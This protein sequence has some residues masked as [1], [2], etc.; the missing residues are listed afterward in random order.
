[1]HLYLQVASTLDL[2]YHTCKLSELVTT[3][4]TTQQI[5]LK[6]AAWFYPSPPPKYP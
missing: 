2:L 5:T 1:M 6:H 4:V 3:L